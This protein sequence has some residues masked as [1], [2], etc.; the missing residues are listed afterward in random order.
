M[1]PAQ[2]FVK[3]KNSLLVSDISA[4]VFCAQFTSA[5]ILVDYLR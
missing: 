5:L 2:F 4:G 1:M 3:Q